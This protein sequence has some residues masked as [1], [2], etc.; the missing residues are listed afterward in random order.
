[1]DQARAATSEGGGPS[2]HNDRSMTDH[3]NWPQS[4]EALLE[5]ARQCK[6]AGIPFLVGLYSSLG[7]SLDPAFI[8][9]LQDLGIDTIPL[10]PAWKNIPENV[11]HV[12]RIDSHP[13]A[14]VHQSIAE[15]LVNIFLQR[16]WLD[17]GSHTGR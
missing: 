15:Y 14:L 4:K 17:D 12:S 9:D 6:E 16:G 11:A 3:P 7:S 10:Q 2:G 13:S 8:A 5:I 1:M